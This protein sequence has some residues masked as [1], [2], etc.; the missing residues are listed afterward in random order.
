[1]SQV[2]KIALDRIRELELQLE[3]SQEARRKLS[4]LVSKLTKGNAP[5]MQIIPPERRDFRL[6]A[7]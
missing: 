3:Q 6:R 2:D 7:I 5:V 4:Q 1:M